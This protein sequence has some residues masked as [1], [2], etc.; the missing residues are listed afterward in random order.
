MNR[1]PWVGRGDR[2]SRIRYSLWC[3]VLI[4]EEKMEIPPHLCQNG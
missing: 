2:L 3:E 4:F 1:I